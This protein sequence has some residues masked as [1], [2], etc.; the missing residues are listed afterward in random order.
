MAR[1]GWNTGLGW[2]MALAAVSDHAQDYVR[3]QLHGDHLRC[4]QCA[5][6]LGNH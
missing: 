2:M 5:Q 4:T 6:H 3:S 1:T